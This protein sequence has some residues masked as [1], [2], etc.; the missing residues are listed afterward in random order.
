DVVGNAEALEVFKFLG[1][2][3][4]GKSLLNW[5]TED[6][7]EA[8]EALSD[9]A[10]QPRGGLEAFIGHTC[11]KGHPESH[12]LAKHLYFPETRSGVHL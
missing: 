11:V 8:V 9:N 5:L 12:R 2:Q 10:E 1:L 4:Q 6:R 3:D 7:A